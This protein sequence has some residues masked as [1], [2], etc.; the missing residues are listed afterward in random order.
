MSNVPTQARNATLDELVPILNAQ[1]EAKLDAVVPAQAIRSEGGIIKV[2][3]LGFAGPVGDAGAFRPTD[4]ADSHVADKLG[5]PTAYLRRLRTSRPDLYDANVNGWIHG[6]TEGDEVINAP[7][8]RKFFLRA[9]RP[10]DPWGEGIF[11]ALLSD[12]Y[13]PM[14]NLDVIVAA[15]SGVRDSGTPIEVVQANLSESRMRLRVAAPGITALA[16]TL[17]DHY[18]SPNGG[19]T[20]DR[21]REAAARE[22]HGYEPGK[23]P[24]VFAGFDISNS[25]TGGGAFVLT[26]VLTV[27]MCR[28]GLVFTQNALRSVHLG[29]K[30]AEG[31]IRWAEAT[32]QKN[33]ELVQAMAK[34]AVSTFLDAEYIRDLLA[35]VEQ[36]AA[37]ALTN[38]AE[39]VKV[40]SQQMKF[41]DEVTE[42][43]LGHFIKGGQ[44]TAGGILNAV[45][46]FAQEV[47]D[48]DLAN[49]L[50]AGALKALEVA[51]AA[52]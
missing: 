38:P 1:R 28:N 22:G 5:I 46:S 52:A 37:T 3:G 17:L 34:D 16:P 50:E 27:Q 13:K 25:E 8:G 42:G 2:A 31:Q 23:E 19:W 45:T 7:D 39:T 12:S 10:A 41:S 15:L 40:V 48:P 30:M 51:V 43:V 29:A 18:R 35:P 20:V 9:F 44:V 21:A 4:I 32:Q 6:Q 24:V 47:D 49:E 33:V 36:A 26:P 11:R 14:D